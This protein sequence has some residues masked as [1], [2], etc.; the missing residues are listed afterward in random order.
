MGRLPLNKLLIQLG[1]L[2]PKYIDL[3]LN[4]LLN[5]LKKLNNPHLKL[6][7]TIHI[8]GTNGKGSTLSFIH[9]ILKENS[10]KVHCYISPHLESFEERIILSNRKITKQKL[11]NTLSYVK[12]INNKDPITFFEITTAAAFYLF[13]KS[14]A[15]FLILETG[16]GGRL[17]AT[18]VIEQSVIDIIT[19][20]SLDHKEFLGSNLKKITDEKLGIIKSS[21]S[22]IIGKQSTEITSYIK[23]NIKKNKNRKL[24]YGK[25]FKVLKTTNKHFV[26]DLNNKI[27][28]FNIP[29]LIGHHQIENSST[30]IA[31][32]YEIK[33]Q[34]YKIIHSL[35][36]DGLVKTIWPGRLEKRYLKKIPVYID[37]A[38]NIAGAKQLCN[39]LNKNK[40][41][42]WIIFGML[43]NKDLYNFLNQIKKFIS[44]VIAVR[45]PEEK[46]SFTTQEI[47][48][49]CEKLKIECIKQKNIKSANQYLLRLIK[50]ERIVITG[51]LYLIGKARKLLN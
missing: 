28:K 47:F 14:S 20:I 6:P 4:R 29:S 12:K 9:H 2:H 11:Y 17:D 32:A 33:K 41:N 35:I 10:Y 22:I 49:V 45:I 43:N 50:P 19:P 42:T 24:F 25:N 51:S 21:S 23:K 40:K 5:L 31:T 39:F 18:N 8:A 3:S 7:P 26:L 37:G 27:L 38:H 1:K 46:N 36:N 30:A 44:G 34:G 16:L 48:T 13:N 15:D